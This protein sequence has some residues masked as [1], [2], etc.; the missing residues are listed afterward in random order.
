VDED[1]LAVVDAGEHARLFGRERVATTDAQQVDVSRDRL[2]RRAQ[3]VTHA[4]EK[5]DLGA[6]HLLGRLSRPLGLDGASRL[7]NRDH[8]E[9]RAVLDQLEHLAA[10]AARSAV[11]HHHLA[12]D[13][14]VEPDQ[15]NDLERS[16][17]DR[18]RD[19]GEVLLAPRYVADDDPAPLGQ[20]QTEGVLA[21]PVTAEQR[22]L[23]VG[24]ALRRRGNDDSGDLIVEQQDRH[25]G[26]RQGACKFQRR[27]Q[28]VGWHGP[29]CVHPLLLHGGCLSGW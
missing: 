12:D 20:R 29:R 24:E 7:L 19:F 26:F 8:D 25:I 14:V 6:S 3:L 4:R 1:L 11:H 2:Q 13:L 17:A 15:R 16:E 10:R 22:R 27:S 5:L 9:A 18:S 28:V 23:R 21:Q